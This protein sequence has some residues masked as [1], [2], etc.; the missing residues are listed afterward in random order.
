MTLYC[1]RC[2]SVEVTEHVSQEAF[3]AIYHGGKPNDWELEDY[4]D[5][6]RTLSYECR[7]CGRGEEADED[8]TMTLEERREEEKYG[9]AD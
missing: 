5:V 3:I 8:W 1:P 7:S 4:G 9:Q 2:G 6:I